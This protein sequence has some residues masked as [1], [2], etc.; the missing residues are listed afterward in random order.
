MKKFL[1]A[2][3]LIAFSTL[4]AHAADNPWV[5]TWKLDTAKSHFTGETHTYSKTA[6]GMM[7][8]SN[9]STISYDFAIDGK[10]YKAPG[11]RTVVW[12]ADGDNTWTTVFKAGDGATVSTVNRT[13]SADG[14]TLTNVA[15]GTRPD[16]SPFKT[17]AVDTRVTGTS[18]LAGQWRDTKVDISAAETFTFSIPSPGVFRMEYPEF[19][20]VVEGK[21]DGTDHPLTGG[22][23]PAGLTQSFKVTSP[24]KISYVNKLDGKP[25]VYGVQTLAADGKSF[26]DVSWK[27]GKGSEKEPPFTS[28]SNLPGTRKKGCNRSPS[29][30]NSHPNPHSSHMPLP[31]FNRCH[32]CKSVL[33]LPRPNRLQMLRQHLLHHPAQMWPR[34]LQCS[35]CRQAIL[36]AQSLHLAMLDKLIRPAH[37]NHRHLHIQPI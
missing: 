8:Y 31:V 28:N 12:T 9:D 4:S 35:L 21:P 17:E 36:R 1:I 25:V 15:T 13:L 24:T 5:G 2:C 16:G 23:A 10:E 27:P 29:S 20:E 30:F 3:A 18:G 14:K 26:T 6:N 11:N 37:A 33:S 7:H 22:H 34:L 32:R 19:Q